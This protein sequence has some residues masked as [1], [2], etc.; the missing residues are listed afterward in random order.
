MVSVAT[1]LPPIVVVG[2][3]MLAFLYVASPAVPVVL[4][5]TSLVRVLFCVPRLIV[6]SVAFVVN[7]EPVAPL[8]KIPDCVM[9][10]VVA[11][12]TSLPPTVEAARSMPP[13]S[14]NDASPVPPSVLSDTLPVSVLACDAR[15]IAQ[16]ELLLVNLLHVAPVLTTPDCVMPPV[17]AVTTSLP[18]TVEAARSMPPD[19][20]NDAS[21]VP[22][23]VL[24]D[25]LPVSVLVCEARSIV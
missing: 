10:P 7:A 23:S 20:F 21:P 8:D 22:P 3:L 17:V 18:P 16:R 11:V 5:V 13:D 9:L 12:T 15:P 25:T 6:A 1:S 14:F 4:K 19:S 24:S 2:K